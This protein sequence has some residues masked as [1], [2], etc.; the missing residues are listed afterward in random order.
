MV[1][2]CAGALFG[3]PGSDDGGETGKD[4]YIGDGRFGAEEGGMSGEMGVE[5]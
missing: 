1:S 2:L 4:C 5:R 3:G